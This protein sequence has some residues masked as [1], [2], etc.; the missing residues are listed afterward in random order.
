MLEF[1]LA[2]LDGVDEGV[3]ALYVEKD[4][5]FQL[6]V[7]GIE[8]VSGLKSQQATLLSE[9]KAAK[10]ETRLLREQQTEAEQSRQKEKGEFEQLWKTAEQEKNETSV[11]LTEL[12][13]ANKSKEVDLISG[14]LALL[15]DDPKKVE[16]LSVIAKQFVKD[17][18]D[19]LKIMIDDVEVQVNDVQQRLM[20]DYPFLVDGS[21]ATGS[22]ASGQGSGAGNGKQ[23]TRAEFNAKG[24]GDRAA[25]VKDGGKIIE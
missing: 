8:D 21:K 11:K 25:F 15:S 2:N 16:L 9:A 4:G 23:I 3:K 10:E 5:A 17:T 24:Q 22:G 6:A 20:K 18:E 13:A 12:I 14:K 7:S 19:G 1:Q